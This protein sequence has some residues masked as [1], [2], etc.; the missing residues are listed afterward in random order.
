MTLACSTSLFLIATT[1]P[2]DSR[3]SS[4]SLILILR[5]CYICKTFLNNNPQLLHYRELRPLR[6]GGWGM[7]NV[8]E[9]LL[10]YL[11]Q[12]NL[13]FFMYKIPTK[14]L[15]ESS[16]RHANCVTPWHHTFVSQ[17]GRF[18]PNKDVSITLYSV[19]SLHVRM[20]SYSYPFL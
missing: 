15:T 19:L 2:F 5:T 8:H 18:N 3:D 1:E 12:R 11:N 20:P 7:D 17:Q 14:L 6:D 16:R 4:V 10:K 13:L 9:S